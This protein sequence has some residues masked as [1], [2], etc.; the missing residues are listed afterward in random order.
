MR[1]EWVAAGILSIRKVLWFVLCGSI[2]RQKKQGQGIC[3]QGQNCRRKDRE[4]EKEG[5]RKENRDSGE[6]TGGSWCT[7]M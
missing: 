2:H 4:E 7:C 6:T 1:E 5:K 3:A